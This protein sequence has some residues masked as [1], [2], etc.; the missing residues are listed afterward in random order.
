MS[1]PHKQKQWQSASMQTSSVKLMCIPVPAYRSDKY[2]GRFGIYSTC[3]PCMVL[4]NVQSSMKYELMLLCRI[5][6]LHRRTKL[7]FVDW[8]I[9]A[10][11][12]HKTSGTRHSENMISPQNRTET[13]MRVKLRAMKLLFKKKKKK[14]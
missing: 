6:F 13:Q 8:N 7:G 2:P 12:N 5:F 10:A 14:P 3:G 9:G 1:Y 11:H 4:D